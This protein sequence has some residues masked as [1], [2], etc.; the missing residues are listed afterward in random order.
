MHNPF[1]H[2]NCVFFSSQ[3][4]YGTKP[5]DIG[6]GETIDIPK[7]LRKMLPE[8]IWQEYLLEHSEV[9]SLGNIKPGTYSGQIGRKDFLQILHSY[10]GSILHDMHV[11]AIVCEWYCNPFL[12][13]GQQKN[14]VALDDK[15]EVYGHENFLNLAKFIDRLTSFD[16]ELVATGEKL[17]DMAKK[18]HL[19][20]KS[21]YRDHIRLNSS[22]GS[23]CLGHWWR[24]PLL[25]QQLWQAWRPLFFVRSSSAVDSGTQGV[26]W[27]SVRA[28]CW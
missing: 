9:D 15:S 25:P 7:V 2:I 3:V 26:P 6:N 27:P 13:G 22:V 5:L 20:L 24:R 21:N 17:K 11:R 14:H 1:Q 16:R 10:S 19:H 4:A 8:K 28:S 23:H 18:C 12:T